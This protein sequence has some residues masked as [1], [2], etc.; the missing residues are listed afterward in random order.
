MTM[1]PESAIKEFIEIYRKHY[2]VILNTEEARIK[3]QNFLLFFKSISN[4][5]SNSN[6]NI[7]LIKKGGK[8][9]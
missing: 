1:L 4:E 9:I 7:N 3:A 2:G 8:E 5:I 6:M